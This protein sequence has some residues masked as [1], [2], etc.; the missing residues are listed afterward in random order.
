MEIRMRMSRKGQLV[1]PKIIREFLG[2][3]PGDEVIMEVRGK[4]V[5]IKPKMDPVKF[6]E[7]FCSR[8]GKKL[9]EKIDL[10][11]MLEGE[12]EERLVLR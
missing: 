1:I 3:G 6:V 11:R 4:E 12:V 10:E 5:L 7:D 2:V 9:T 8:G